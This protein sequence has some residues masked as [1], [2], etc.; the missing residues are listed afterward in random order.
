MSKRSINVT[1][2]SLRRMLASD[3]GVLFWRISDLCG[4]GSAIYFLLL[5]TSYTVKGFIFNSKPT[6]TV[7]FLGLLK[8]IFKLFVHFVT[9]VFRN[10]T[11]SMVPSSIIHKFLIPSSSYRSRRR[12]SIIGLTLKVDVHWRL[13]FS[14]CLENNNK[15]KQLMKTCWV[16]FSFGVNYR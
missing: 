11:F 4:L 2:N 5:S 15:T 9:H 14:F 3:S 13:L 1:A 8:H 12:L 6:D 16:I 10:I 7:E